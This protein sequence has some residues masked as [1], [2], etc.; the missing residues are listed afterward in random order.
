MGSEMD[1]LSYAKC[2]A[3][4]CEHTSCAKLQQH[5]LSRHW[6]FLRWVSSG[7]TTPRDLLRLV[8]HG[9]GNMLFRICCARTREGVYE[10]VLRFDKAQFPKRARELMPP[11]LVE[12]FVTDSC[13]AWTLDCCLNT[14]VPEAE[15]WQF[16]LQG[17][18][19]ELVFGDKDL[20]QDLLTEVKAAIRAVH[21]PAPLPTATF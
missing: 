1:E 5:G 11:P 3:P 7:F 17:G 18:V 2:V 16:R 9:A 12:N 19:G 10:A 8:H 4:A 13:R 20:P 15:F 14:L 6:F 21:G